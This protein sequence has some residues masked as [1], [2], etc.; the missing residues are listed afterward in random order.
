M[1][2]CSAL[3]VIEVLVGVR[4]KDEPDTEAFLG[5]LRAYSVDRPVAM[6]AASLIRQY[7][8]RGRILQLADAAIAATCMA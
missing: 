7:R 2:G 5:S 1:L 8:T 3:S 6:R 4:P